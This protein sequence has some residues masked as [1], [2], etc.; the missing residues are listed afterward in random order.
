VPYVDRAQDEHFV[1]LPE[2]NAL[3]AGVRK[4]P[5]TL[6]AWWGFYVE[7]DEDK[8]FKF[9]IDDAISSTDGFFGVDN[10]VSEEAVR[11]LAP[12]V[13]HECEFHPIEIKGTP[14]PYYAL[15]IK[16]HIPA[17]DLSKA[18][19]RPVGHNVR[20]GEPCV[21]LLTYEFRDEMVKDRFLF[22]LTGD[23]LDEGSLVDYATDRFASLVKRLGITGFHFYK[24]KHDFKA[25][26]P[27]KARK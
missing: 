3:Q 19:V 21:R 17:V 23:Q 16:D 6:P 26:V 20:N 11:A 5:S 4:F 1:L 2:V 8:R 10:F 15:W 24:A 12:H 7:P 14:Q 22:R 13:G 9:R 25:W 18:Q 27:V